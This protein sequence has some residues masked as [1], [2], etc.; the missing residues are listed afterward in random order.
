MAL[1]CSPYQSLAVKDIHSCQLEM[2][3]W[4]EAAESTLGRF[5]DSPRSSHSLLKADVNLRLHISLTKPFGLC[6]H[7]PGT[8]KKMLNGIF[9]T[10]MHGSGK[11]ILF[12]TNSDEAMSKISP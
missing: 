6:S 2:D 12:K 8:G 3:P 10:Q 1:C 9:R 11:S 7:Y 4:K 5:P